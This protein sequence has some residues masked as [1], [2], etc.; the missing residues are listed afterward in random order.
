MSKYKRN[1]QILFV[2]DK[3]GYMCGSKWDTF[4]TG[5]KPLKFHQSNPYTI[6]NIKHYMDLN[7]EGYELLSTEYICNSDKLLFKCPKGHE[8]KMCWG[9]FQQGKK[10]FYMFE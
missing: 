10:M 2:K 7:T 5:T 8:F 3:D 4:Q 6:Q 9:S 1:N